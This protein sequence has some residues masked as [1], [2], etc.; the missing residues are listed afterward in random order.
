[1]VQAERSIRVAGLISLLAL[2]AA[3]PAGYFLMP[4]VFVFPE[5]LPERLAFAAQ[6]SIFVLLCVVIA[7]GMVS[8]ARRFSPEDIGGS[9]ARGPSE[10]IAIYVAFLQNTLEQAV[11]AVGLYFALAT[12]LSGPWLALIPI[13]VLF[14]LVGRVL[15]LRGYSRGVEGRA[16]GM[17]LTMTPTVL[18]YLL[19]IVLVVG[20]WI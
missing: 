19:V 16:L 12:L 5:E 7:I 6:A 2:A 9:A 17:T 15:F 18:G 10:H 13:G 14:F 11:I 1:M 4:A 20:K 8:T 3:V